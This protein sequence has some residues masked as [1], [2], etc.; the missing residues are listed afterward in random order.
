MLESQHRSVRS[1]TGRLSRGTSLTP[2]G[3]PRRTSSILPTYRQ[4]SITESSSTITN[5][6]G[7]C[8][9]CGA[10]R[11]SFARTTARHGCPSVTSA[12]SSL[13]QARV[14]A[15][16][17]AKKRSGYLTNSDHASGWRPA[18]RRASR[19]RRRETGNGHARRT[20]KVSDPDRA[21]SALITPIEH[22]ARHG[23]AIAPYVSH[24]LPLSR[25]MEALALAADPQ[26]SAKVLVI[27]D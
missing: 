24:R 15:R 25:I 26:R 18:S 21:L 19:W 7:Q 9:A 8:A 4:G 6:S 2:R 14:T 20:A 1:A 16:K 22:L 27:P 13:V 3:S 17:S 5:V 23:D 10:V 12:T 11:L